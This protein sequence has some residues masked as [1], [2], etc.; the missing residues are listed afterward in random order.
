MPQTTRAGIS[1]RSRCA[2]PDASTSGGELRYRRRIARWVPWSKWS[3]TLSS[4]ASRHRPRRRVHVLGGVPQQGSAGRS[5]RELAQ[6]GGAPDA[7]PAVPA[8]A[9]Q[10]RHGVDDHEPL[11]AL[12]VALGEGQAHGA[13]VV[14]HEAHALE[15]LIL[16]EALDEVRVLVDRVLQLARL[17]RTAEAGEVGCEATGPLQ[18]RQPVVRVG[19]HAV[20]VQRRS[21]APPRVWRRCARTEAARR[22]PPRDR[23]HRA[24]GEDIEGVR[25][26]AGG[27]GTVSR[28]P[29][30]PDPPARAHLA[31]APPRAGRRPGGLR[32]R[33]RGSRGSATACARCTA[34]R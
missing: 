3:S 26:I 23:S 8:V 7:R 34:S 19:R 6:P 30:S 5:H 21:P 29:P 18:E 2:P 14:H 9:G 4:Q 15:V 25:L 22:A 27:A 28:C 16:E 32:R 13:P 12:G 20:Q 31:G 33:A 1:R 24:P 17:A 10:E 11:H